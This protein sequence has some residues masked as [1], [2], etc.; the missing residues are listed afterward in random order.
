MAGGS[1]GIGLKMGNGVIKSLALPAKV[2]A[3][4]HL[5]V[6][7]TTEDA[8][9]LAAAAK[10]ISPADLLYAI[11][12]SAAVCDKQKRAQNKQ[13]RPR[14]VFSITKRARNVLSRLSYPC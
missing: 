11:N 2:A 1:A 5:G 12:K 7:D 8:S 9:V 4:Y 13:K 3:R 10:T 6:L 14:N